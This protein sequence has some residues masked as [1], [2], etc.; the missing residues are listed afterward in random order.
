[1]K[2]NTIFFTK[3]KYRQ[4][5]NWSVASGGSQY[6][7]NVALTEGRMSDNKHMICI[8]LSVTVCN[9]SAGEVN[10]TLH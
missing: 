2:Q 10:V 3:E 9:L 5:F 7:E 1:M 4:I 8:V 6:I